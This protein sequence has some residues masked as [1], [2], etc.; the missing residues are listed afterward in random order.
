MRYPQTVRRDSPVRTSGG[1]RGKWKGEVEIRERTWSE[2]EEE[3]GQ[4]RDPEPASLLV[5]DA[6][7]GATMPPYADIGASP[8]SSHAYCAIAKSFTPSVSTCE[9]LLLPFHL[10]RHRELSYLFYK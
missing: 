2:G 9:I 8:V 5:S 7:Y 1:A 3:E 6:R 10:L 4:A